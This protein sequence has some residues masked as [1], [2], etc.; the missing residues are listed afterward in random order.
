MGKKITMSDNGNDKKVINFK[1]KSNMDKSKNASDAILL[2]KIAHEV[3]EIKKALN[4]F[5]GY[6]V[7]FYVV[8]IIVLLMKL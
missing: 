6:S 1:G 3:G 5:L 8:L 4:I 2:F 7:L